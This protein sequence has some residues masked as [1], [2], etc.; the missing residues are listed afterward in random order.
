MHDSTRGLVSF[1]AVP[2]GTTLTQIT[3]SGT[4][5]LGKFHRPA[6][7]NN[8]IYVTSSNKIIAIGGAAQ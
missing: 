8:H 1:N 4:G 3:V 7:G 5:G 2:S 6:F